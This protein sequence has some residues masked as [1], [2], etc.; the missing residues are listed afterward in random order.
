MS[1]PQSGGSLMPVLVTPR[2]L[3]RQGELYHQLAALTAAGVGLISALEMVSK[4][5][6][7]H[8]FRQPLRQVLLQLEQGATVSAALQSLGRSWLSEFDI[9]LIR[10]GEQS[11]R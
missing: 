6:A 11:G 7:H 8:S 10:A 2:R 1:P 4:G 5:E 9:A 3:E